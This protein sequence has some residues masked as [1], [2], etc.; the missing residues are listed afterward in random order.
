MLILAIITISAALVFYTIG[1]WAER[2]SKDLKLWHV[3]V[4]WC[5]LICDTIGTSIMKSIATNTSIFT[6]H[7]ITGL[8]AILLMLFHAVWATV[9]IYKN[10]QEMKKTFHKFSFIVWLIWL[11]PY[12]TG[13]IVGMKG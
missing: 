9:V 7:G 4:F 5:G 2:L 1:V 11:V 8:L 6:V 12:I 13:L 10:D 3:V